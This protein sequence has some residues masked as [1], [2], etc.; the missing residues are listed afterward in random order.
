MSV[1]ELSGSTAIV[2]G[3]SRGF[4]RATAAALAAGGA[5]VVGV[6]RGAGPLKELEEELGELFTAEVADTTD[7]ALPRRLFA[8][9]RPQTVVLNAGATPVMAP[10][11]Q[12]TWQ[13]FSRNWG[14]DIQQVFNFLRE[15]L[16]A[17]IAEGGVVVSFSSGAAVRGSPL[18]GGY[19][20][21]KATVKLLSS[22]AGSE[23]ARG[24]LGLRF[25]SL[26]P[27]LT[28]ATALGRTGVE[29][30]AERAGLAADV[31]VQQTGFTLTT[32][33]VADAVVKLATDDDYSAAA[34][35]LTAKG[36]EAID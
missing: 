7:P 22:Y 5:H 14:V 24:S 30:Y 15:A 9:Y 33:Q 17:P 32:D 11:Q 13:D 12:Q 18:S 1:R 19:A 26:L 27:Q 6:A 10:L 3:A 25:V 20:G 34:Y 8:Q 23:A 36:L 16:S 21:A 29:A 2:T 31:F 28:D 4:G 35:L